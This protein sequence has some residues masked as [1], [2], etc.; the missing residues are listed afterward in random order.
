MPLYKIEYIVKAL[1]S[2]YAA[3]YTYKYYT[4]KVNFEGEKEARRKERVYNY[5]L[6]FIVLIILL[7]IFGLSFTYDFIKLAL[8]S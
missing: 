1:I 8:T 6:I 7:L 2:F 3:W 4:G 5:G